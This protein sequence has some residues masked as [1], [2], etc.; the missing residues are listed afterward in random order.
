MQSTG[1]GAMQSSQPLQSA[2]ITACMRRGP[3]TIASTGHAWMQIVQ[4]MQRASSTT[5]TARGTWTPQPGSTLV[6]ARPVS[7]ASAAIV[8]S[9]PGGQRLIRAWPSAIACA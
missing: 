7:A 9:P 2:S 1:Q 4:P 8:A 3:P 5:A 6:R